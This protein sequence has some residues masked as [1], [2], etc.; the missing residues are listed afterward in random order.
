MDLSR[1]RELGL[2][3]GQIAAYSAILELGVATLNQIHEKTGLERRSV[4][5]ILNK[6]IERGLVTYITE[7]KKRKYQSAPPN[8]VLV[9]IKQKI[10][11]LKELEQQVP[12]MQDVFAV[13][14]VDVQA[15][16]YRGNDAIKSFLEEVLAY[17][18]SYWLGGNNFNQQ[19][20]V[21]QS[22]VLWFTQ[23][24]KR[25]AE[26]KHMMYDLIQQGTVLEGL[27]LDDFAKQK[28]AYL[29]V[30]RLPEE[31]KFPL[32]IVIFGNKVAQILWSKQSFAFLLESEE[33][34]DSFMKYFKYFWKKD[35]W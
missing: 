27:H 16:V 19:K 21:P 14:K 31:L 29:K 1:L 11:A 25:R 10:S 8:K 32:V 5:D 34:K 18:E 24:M 17:K 2:S 35:P 9:E 15:E 13:P 6:L 28:K 20:A 7:N 22:L 33:V 3:A 12:I 23:W 30:K 4:Y 26:H